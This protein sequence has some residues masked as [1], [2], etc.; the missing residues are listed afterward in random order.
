MKNL[1]SGLGIDNFFIDNNINTDKYKD[2]GKKNLSNKS[3][4]N[5]IN[6]LVIDTICES[7]LHHESTVD[8][9]I[10]NY[11]TVTIIDKNKCND[12]STTVVNSMDVINNNNVLILSIL[13]TINLMIND[14]FTHIT[15]GNN[16]NKLNSYLYNISNNIVHKLDECIYDA[17]NIINIQN[18]NSIVDNINIMKEK[19]KL[20]NDFIL[21]NMNNIQMTIDELKQVLNDITPY[22]IYTSIKECPRVKTD[23]RVKLVTK[24]LKTN[25]FISNVSLKICTNFI[26]NITTI[27]NN[28]LNTTTINITDQVY[29]IGDTIAIIIKEYTNSSNNFLSILGK[30]LLITVII[31]IIIVI[32]VYFI[33]PIIVKFVK[34]QNIYL[35][36]NSNN[37]GVKTD[38]S[39]PVLVNIASGVTA[40]DVVPSLSSS[41]KNI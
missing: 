25:S 12:N 35:F 21:P 30:S 15:N 31:I 32:I 41:P 29:N 33:L 27:L 39:P 5:D 36:N 37:D 13:N 16:K 34:T 6:K 17:V 7:I 22:N 18:T 23:D 24:D 4:I 19:Y 8:Q 1:F 28:I 3:L 20:S 38:M 11:N 14:I 26:N 10:N 2:L 40:A 9:L